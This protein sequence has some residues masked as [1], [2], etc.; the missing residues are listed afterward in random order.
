MYELGALNVFWGNHHEVTADDLRAAQALANLAAVG[1]AQQS[2]PVSPR[3]LAE[4]V[5][6]AVHG[7]I[8]IEQAKG[9]LAIQAG[10]TVGAAFELMSAHARSNQVFV[11]AVARQVVDREVTATQMQ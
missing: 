7:R 1:L 2:A 10:I 3:N 6:Y 8:A 5:E 4:E 11:R 9:M